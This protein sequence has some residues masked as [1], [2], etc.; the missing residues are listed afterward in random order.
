MDHS[1]YR[2]KNFGLDDLALG[3]QPAQHGRMQKAAALVSFDRFATPV[4]DDLRA[5]SNTLPDQGFDSGFRWMAN[6]RPHL[7]T[8]VQP[9]PGHAGQG[10]F[11]NRAG[12]RFLSLANSKHK[13][14]G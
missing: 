10:G 1:Q 13:R 6:H 14:S 12:K 3:M 5:L 9:E 8:I 2:T 7:Y 4:Y 11:C